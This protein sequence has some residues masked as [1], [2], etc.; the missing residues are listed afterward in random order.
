MKTLQSFADYSSY[1]K[2]QPNGSRPWLGL[3]SVIGHM[4]LAACDGIC[5]WSMLH[6]NRSRVCVPLVDVTEHCRVGFGPLLGQVWETYAC[7]VLLVTGNWALGQVR[8]CDVKKHDAVA[9][10]VVDLWWVECHQY[11]L[12]NVYLLCEQ[13][14]QQRGAAVIAAR[15]LS[16]AMSAAKATCDHLRDWWHGTKDVSLFLLIVSLVWLSSSHWFICCSH[17]LQLRCRVKKKHRVSWSV[18]QCNVGLLSTIIGF[19]FVN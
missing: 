10:T 18:G 15:K 3:A 12:Y 14:V 4:S 7:T 8:G 2:K 17:F 6:E 1:F 11:W 19:W 5:D 16:S 9:V 13:T